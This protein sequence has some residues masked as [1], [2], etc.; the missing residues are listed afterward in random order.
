MHI[1][2]WCYSTN[3]LLITTTSNLLKC[4]QVASLLSLVSLISQFE[5][6]S[7]TC[8]LQHFKSNLSVIS[9]FYIKFIYVQY[10]TRVS[11][12]KKETNSSCMINAM[13]HV[14][15]HAIPLM[16]HV[17]NQAVW[18]WHNSKFKSGFWLIINFPNSALTQFKV[19]L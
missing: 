17:M 9:D 18:T 8:L 14:T 19:H 11:A 12:K 10:W 7:T 13:V 2:T 3:H 15:K 4:V 5:L 6:F 1:S 16:I